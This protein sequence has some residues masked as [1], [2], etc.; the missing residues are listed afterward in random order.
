MTSRHRVQ[1]AKEGQAGC[2]SHA[3]GPGLIPAKD[4]W[5]GGGGSTC[6]APHLTEAV[7]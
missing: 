3:G 4:S 1:E 2:K 6:P 7:P 5:R